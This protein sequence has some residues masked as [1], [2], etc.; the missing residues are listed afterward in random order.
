MIDGIFIRPGMMLFC[1][2]RLIN[3]GFSGQGVQRS[4]SRRQLIWLAG[5]V[6]DLLGNMSLVPNG[7]HGDRTK[8]LEQLIS[9]VV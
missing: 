3:C 2:E 9:N 4:F 6:V 5:T 7:S 8:L 1:T